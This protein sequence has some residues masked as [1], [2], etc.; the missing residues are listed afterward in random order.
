MEKAASK[1][2]CNDRKVDMSIG[3][4]DVVE[5]EMRRECEGDEM[6]VQHCS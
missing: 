1:I 4:L 5:D 6:D 2:I 3:D